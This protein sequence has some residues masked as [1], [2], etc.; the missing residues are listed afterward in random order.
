MNATTKTPVNSIVIPAQFVDLCGQWYNGIGDLL[1][2]V[3]STGNLTTGDRRPMG[4]DSNEKWYLILWKRLAN[5]VGHAAH[6]AKRGYNA[7][8]DGGDGN[9]HDRDYPLLVEFETYADKITKRLSTEYGLD[10]WET[11]VA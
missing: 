11:S 2:A 7:A 6:C 4:C 1:Y 9:G 5:D 8:D 3:S 10:E